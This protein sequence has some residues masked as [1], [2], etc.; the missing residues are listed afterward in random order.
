[1]QGGGARTYLGT[2]R[3]PASNGTAPHLAPTA[4]VLLQ[5]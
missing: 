1:M 3:F 2:V 4:P 5:S